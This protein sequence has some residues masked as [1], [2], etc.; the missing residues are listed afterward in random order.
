LPGFVDPAF[1]SLRGGLVD[2]RAEE[3]ALVLRITGLQLLHRMH[4]PLLEVVVKRCMRIDALH[5]DAALS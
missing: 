1:E 3:H 2:H 4:E 5:A